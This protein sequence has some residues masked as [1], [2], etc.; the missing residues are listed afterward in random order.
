MSSRVAALLDAF[1]K[2]Q[3]SSL[4]TQAEL[5]QEREDKLASR[6]GGAGMHIVSIHF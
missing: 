4:Q 6:A 3:K 1:K 2:G 5:R